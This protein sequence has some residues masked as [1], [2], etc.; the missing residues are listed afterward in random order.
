MMILERRASFELAG[1]ASSGRV[2]WDLPLGLIADLS[3]KDSDW[4][5]L[6]LVLGTTHDQ[7]HHSTP[8][9]NINMDPTELTRAAFFNSLKEAEAMRR[10]KQ[11]RRVMQLTKQEQ[12]SLWD[13]LCSAHGGYHTFSLVEEKLLFGS[14]A[15]STSGNCMMAPLKVYE[16]VERVRS[17]PVRAGRDVS[18][19]EAVCQVTGKKKWERLVLHGIELDPA[20]PITELLEHLTFPDTMVHLAVF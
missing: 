3:G 13:A 4:L 20:T 11:H 10:N 8:T 9:I 6:K 2:R 16:S 17:G 18:V 5:E 14:S 7:S 12:C 19:M 1:G 15:G